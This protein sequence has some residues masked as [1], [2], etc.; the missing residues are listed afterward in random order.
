MIGL[1]QHLRAATS[2]IFT[3]A[4]SSSPM[5][6]MSPAGRIFRHQYGSAGI[7][8]SHPRRV[9]VHIAHHADVGGMVPGSMAGG[10]QIIRKGCGFLWCGSSAGKAA[11]GAA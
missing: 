7:S 10:V 8:S 4:I 1:M 6:R 9:H 2:A 11:A 3:P 5:T